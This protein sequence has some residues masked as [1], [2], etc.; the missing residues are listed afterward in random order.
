MMIVHVPVQYT[1]TID[2]SIIYRT[3]TVPG[4]VLYLCRY[5]GVLGPS[6]YGNKIIIHY[7]NLEYNVGPV[8]PVFLIVM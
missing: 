3:R 7:W 4:P 5:T 1:V 6:V 2:K 8:G